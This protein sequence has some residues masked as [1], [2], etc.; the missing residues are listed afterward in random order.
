MPSSN[1]HSSLLDPKIQTSIFNAVQQ[2]NTA[3]CSYIQLLNSMLLMCEHLW[4]RLLVRSELQAHWCRIDLHSRDRILS[5]P[6]SLPSGHRH[7]EN[8][9]TF[10]STSW[11]NTTCPKS[12]K[13]R[14]WFHVDPAQWANMRNQKCQHQKGTKGAKTRTANKNK[15]EKTVVSWFPN[16]VFDVA[17]LATVVR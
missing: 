10:L 8:V 15:Y 7:Y 11:V 16:C 5:L 12:E 17:L 6:S 4:D 3:M 13:F 2:Y 9:V 14:R 1:H